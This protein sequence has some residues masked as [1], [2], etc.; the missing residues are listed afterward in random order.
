MGKK[1]IIKIGIAVATILAIRVFSYA[2]DSKIKYTPEEQN[3]Y[4]IGKAQSEMGCEIYK[5]EKT[6]DKEAIEK[7]Q[8]HCLQF[9]DWKKN[10]LEKI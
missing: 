9:M 10:K 2:K 5:N 6:I 3:V 8:R 7:R 4:E 1:F